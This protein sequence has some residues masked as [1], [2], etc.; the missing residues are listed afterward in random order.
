MATANEDGG[1]VEDLK[2]YRPPQNE[3]PNVQF[4]EIIN[5]LRTSFNTPG[6]G[7]GGALLIV[8]GIF[9]FSLFIWLATGFYTV[10]LLYTSPSPRDGATSRMPSS[11]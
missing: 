1:T 8:G 6:L 10:C 7:G 2:M 9:V 4:E 11:A 3:E 5:R